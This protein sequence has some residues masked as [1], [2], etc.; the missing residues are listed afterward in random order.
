VS[1]ELRFGGVVQLPSI[2]MLD[3]MRNVVY[4]KSWLQKTE[5]KEL[6]YMFRDLAASDGD[7]QLMKEQ[8]I[9][10]DNTTI[11]AGSL[12]TEFIK[13]TGHYHPQVPGT[14]LSYTEIYE[15][16]EGVAHYLLQK[17]SGG[18][19]SD[20]VL[21]KAKK[22]DKVVIPPNYGHVTIN[23]GKATLRMANLVSSR[24]T[25]IY[26]PYNEK[27]GGAYFELASGKLV[28]NKTYE[29]L[30]ALRVI[31]AKDFTGFGIPS[32]KDIYS[33]IRSPK[34]LGFLNKPT[35]YPDLFAYAIK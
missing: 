30:P 21:V 12:G 13:T 19:V 34:T 27:A 11:P 2:R 28:P 16:L 18:R 7:R 29:D 3:D 5:N 22:G 1:I 25:S 10:Y 14:D 9:R 15:V 31:D 8:D 33:L 24:F 20:V 35:E 6:Y 32:G 23:C 4:D 26:A 17:E